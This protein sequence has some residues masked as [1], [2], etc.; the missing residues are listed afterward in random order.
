MA[1]LCPLFSGSSG[2]SFYIGSREEG[3]LID[4]GRSA[5]QLTTMLTQCG[6]SIHA[7]KAIF[8]THEHTDHVQ[9]L[10]VFATK[11]HL[12]VYS[13][14]GTLNALKKAG[15]LTTAIESQV[16]DSN[17]IE[18]AGMKI[19]PF[20]VPHDCAEGF[21]YRIHTSD[22]RIVT[23]STDLGYVSEEVH[24]A[25]QGSD[26]VVIESNHDV[27]MLQ[28]GGYPY[29]LKRRILSDI[30]HLSNALCARILP[31]LAKEGTTRFMLAHL[32]R[33]NNTPDLAYQTAL[34]S[35]S[36]AGLKQGIDFELSVAPRENT[37]YRTLL[38]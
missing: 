21:G 4:A 16:V 34:C 36:M 23:F 11:N 7:V 32:S 30:G 28:N 24:Q 15:I 37:A 22:G 1:R 38:F 19:Q 20:H 8:V 29:P 3:I 31:E 26:L 5:K 6:I 9:G 12:K 25:L 35:L 27:G 2:N 13:S 17:G 33:E 10:R 14:S 18:C